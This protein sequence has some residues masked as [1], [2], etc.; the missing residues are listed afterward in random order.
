M[1]NKHQKQ[2]KTPKR[3]TWKISKSIWRKRRQTTKKQFRDKYQNLPEEQK[4]MLLEYMKNY[5]L[6][7]K[8]SL[9]N[10]RLIRFV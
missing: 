5:Y 10:F 3:S 6:A 7:H 9:L 1:T 2:I 4:Q 8:K